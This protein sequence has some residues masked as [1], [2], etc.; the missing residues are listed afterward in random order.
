M[1]KSKSNLSI[2]MILVLSAI[3][4]PAAQAANAEPKSIISPA[5]A[6][7]APG[8]GAGS[9]IDNDQAAYYKKGAATVSRSAVKLLQAA[10]KA[11]NQLLSVKAAAA[12]AD[13][14]Y[15][16]RKAAADAAGMSY[17]QAAALAQSAVIQHDAAVA[18]AEKA[19]ADARSAGQAAAV[20]RQAAN[21]AKTNA[22]KFE[23]YANNLAI[24]ANAWRAAAIAWSRRA[25]LTPSISL[26]ANPLPAVE[27]R[28][29]MTDSITQ[30][31]FTAGSAAASTARTKTPEEVRAN[32]RAMT[33]ALIA[34]ERAAARDTY[35]RA[36]L[37]RLALQHS[38]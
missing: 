30:R 20:A 6:C 35:R 24:N 7:S 12:A 21:T 33:A 1:T 34:G 38:S 28:A 5:A 8:P 19:L 2:A 27:D 23:A 9:N 13:N 25:G 16:S 3:M 15:V 37:R 22:I 32:A 10:I 31:P 17:R 29:M 14:E 4:P 11:R 36:Q 26:G 18:N